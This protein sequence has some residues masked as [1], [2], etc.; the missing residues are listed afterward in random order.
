MKV[1]ISVPSSLKEIKLSQYQ[2]FIKTTKDSEDI[3]L[4]NRQLVGIFCDIPNDVVGRMSKI[5]FNQIVNILTETLKQKPDL[6][7]T[8]RLNGIK[9]G[10][11]P[12]LE[13]ITVD[14]Q[15]DLETFL[16]D[17]KNFNKA[18]AVLYRPITHEH[19]GKYNIE[20]YDGKGQ[21]LDVSLDVV[22]GATAF[23]LNLL[24]DLLNCTQNFIQKEVVKNHKLRKSLAENGVGIKSIMDLQKATYLNLT[25]LENL[26]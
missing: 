21:S 25:R 9:Y 15:A 11:I 12:N 16:E 2:K 3:D 17:T 24:K 23:F 1:K 19:K 6:V 10:F 7:T 26:N 8:F 20:E 14:E 18:M 13:K 4:I 5:K 22:H